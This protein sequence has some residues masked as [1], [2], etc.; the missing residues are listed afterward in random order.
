MEKHIKYPKVFIRP[1]QSYDDRLK[2]RVLIADAKMI[3]GNIRYVF[4]IR[5]LENELRSFTMEDDKMLIDWT[6]EVK[7]SDDQFSK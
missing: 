3:P 4:N 1:N 6:S 7:Y 2:R 5:N